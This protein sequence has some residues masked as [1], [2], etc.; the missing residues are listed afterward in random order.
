HLLKGD[1]KDEP[2]EFDPP[3]GLMRRIQMRI[4]VTSDDRADML[5]L[6]RHALSERRM[7][8]AAKVLTGLVALLMSVAGYVRL[9]EWTK[10]YYTGG[11]GVATAGFL[12]AVG[13]AFW[14][15]G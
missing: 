14:L 4:E 2:K 11:L 3:V 1:V 5:Q 8:L 7:H 9:A 10:G 15:L 13:L 6:A 12:A